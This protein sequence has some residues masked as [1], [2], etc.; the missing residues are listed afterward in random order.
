[1]TECPKCRMIQFRQ[2]RFRGFCLAI[3]S[4][5]LLAVCFPVRDAEG[6]ESHPS[7]KSG[8]ASWYSRASCAREGTSGIMAN[9]RALDDTK[10]TAASWD[11]RMGTELI[12]CRTERATPLGLKRRC[13]SVTVSDRGPAKRLHRQGRILDLSRKSFAALADLKE[14]VIEITVEPIPSK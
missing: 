5:S 6:L 9:G 7:A 12:V 14:G 8:T 2:H 4:A 10:A 11:Y 13:T 1:M 3:L